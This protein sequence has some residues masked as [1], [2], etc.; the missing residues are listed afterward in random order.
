M[1]HQLAPCYTVTTTDQIFDLV[2]RKPVFGVSYL[3]MLKPGC[4]ATEISWNVEISHI[5]NIAI[6]LF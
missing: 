2:V 5:L 3:V 6:I 1:E 4:S